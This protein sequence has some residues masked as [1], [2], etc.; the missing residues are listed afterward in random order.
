MDKYGLSK[1]DRA[2]IENIKNE[3]TDSLESIEN[4]KVLSLVNY[5]MINQLL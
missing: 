5:L 2:D 4:S 3:L 1:E